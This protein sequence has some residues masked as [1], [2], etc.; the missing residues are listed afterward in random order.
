METFSTPQSL[1]P[2]VGNDV[3]RKE[4]HVLSDLLI[5]QSSSVFIICVQLEVLEFASY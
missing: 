5:D 2:S 1:T 3:L 4:D